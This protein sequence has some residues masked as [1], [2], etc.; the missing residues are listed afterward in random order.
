M[1]IKLIIAAAFM[2]AN[3]AAQDVR[4]D[5]SRNPDIAGCNYMAYPGPRQTS[6]TPSPQGYTPFYISHY[7]RH[8]SRYLISQNDYDAPLRKLRLANERQLLTD[9]GKEVL[10]KV[11]RMKAESNNRLGELTPLGAQQHRDIA[12]RMV[13]RFPE[14]FSDSVTVNAKST[15]VIRCI[16][17]M[18][19][20]LMQMAAMKPTLQFVHDASQH[21][22]YYMNQ[23]TKLLDS[24]KNQPQVKEAIKTFNDTHSHSD[25]LMNMLFTCKEQDSNN[26]TAAADII[27]SKERQKQLYKQ[28]ID[29]A[30]ALQN[31]ELRHEFTL[32][33]IF[34]TDELYENWQRTNAWW[35]QN[36]G[37]SPLTG[38]LQPYSQR[39]LLRKIIEETDSCLKLK[40]PGATLRFG[41]EGMV[42]SLTCLLDINN[43]A[44]AT[45]LDSLEQHQWLSHN[46]F[47]MAC[48][49]QFVFYRDN[50]ESSAPILLKVLLNENEATLPIATNT[51]PYYRWDDFRK[52]AL[53]ILD[54]YPQS[55][56]Q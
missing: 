12:R 20:E 2:A 25:R 48:N 11:E 56:G 9:K 49:L 3:T 36:N 29:L 42:M 24:L 21:D 31:T 32:Y 15:V 54:K 16:L 4:N 6:L 44:V 28:L 14:V 19:N 55:Q 45:S 38:S 23:S 10:T 40:D 52:Y 53:D 34:N 26:P 17:S 7:G 30:T 5:I 27:M 37:F 50:N 33:D 47:P 41:H 8:G 18:E 13:E 51:P 46:I 35:Y 1:K 39:N 43:N 22:M